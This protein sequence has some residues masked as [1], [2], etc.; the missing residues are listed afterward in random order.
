MNSLG[1]FAHSGSS[2]WRLVASLQEPFSSPDTSSQRRTCRVYF[3][4][5]VHGC[6]FSDR[7]H[8][9]L[10]PR[11]AMIDIIHE[12]SHLVQFKGEGRKEIWSPSRPEQSP[13]CLLLGPK[14]IPTC[15]KR[16]TRDRS[17]WMSERPFDWFPIRRFRSPDWI[18]QGLGRLTRIFDGLRSD[19]IGDY[20][21]GA[22]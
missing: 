12:P 6:H 15:P 22:S 11:V 7:P 14:S 16:E 8:G 2:S 17:Q 21:D 10:R 13:C 5:D 9:R 19:T 4:S 1:A 18:F 20:R 3:M